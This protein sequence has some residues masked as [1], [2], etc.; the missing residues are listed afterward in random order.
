MPR[1]AQ[2]CAAR[3]DYLAANRRR[4]LENAFLSLVQTARHCRQRPLEL[5]QSAACWIAMVMVYLLL[6]FSA[7][8]WETALPEESAGAVW[9]GAGAV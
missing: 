2:P 4:L 6:D 5:L 7:T 8:D 1:Q 3:I 9:L